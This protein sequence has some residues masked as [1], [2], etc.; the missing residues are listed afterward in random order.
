MK[1]AHT[2]DT[3]DVYVYS[4]SLS[5]PLWNH[6]CQELQTPNTTFFV[7]SKP[8]GKKHGVGDGQGCSRLPAASTVQ[9]ATSSL[10]SFL[11]PNRRFQ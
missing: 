10:S 9:R 3:S 11:Y 2:D 8:R 7:F 6:G 5:I 1:V 4:V